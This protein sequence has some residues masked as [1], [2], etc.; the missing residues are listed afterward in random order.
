M[1]RFFIVI[2]PLI[3]QAKAGEVFQQGLIIM[4]DQAE[5]E[6]TGYHKKALTVDF[7]GALKSEIPILASKSIVYNALRRSNPK[8]LDFSEKII[9]VI[10]DFYLI[11]PLESEDELKDQLKFENLPKIS[12][13]EL[14]T[15]FATRLKMT[16]QRVNEFVETNKSLYSY[17][18]AP[19]FEKGENLIR[20]TIFGRKWRTNKKPHT[21]TKL[22]S[23]LENLMVSSTS[24]SWT[25]YLVGHG[26]F[27]LI[28]REE[29]IADL[30]LEE[31]QKFLDFCQNKIITE[32]LLYSSCYAGGTNLEKAFSSAKKGVEE[33]KIYKFPIVVMGVT[34]APSVAERSQDFEGLFSSLFEHQNDL[35]NY[36]KILRD[37]NFI[38]FLQNLPQVRLPGEKW[39]SI[40]DISSNKELMVL[41]KNSVPSFNDIL[42]I[43]NPPTHTI[44]VYLEDV[45]F[46][47]KLS[48]RSFTVPMRFILMR[49]DVTSYHFAKIETDHLTLQSVLAMFSSVARMTPFKY[50]LY[51]DLLSC[52]HNDKDTIRHFKN[53]IIELGPR[54]AK[55]YGVRFYATMNDDGTEVIEYSATTPRNVSSF[56][57]GAG[58]QDIRENRIAGLNY[59]AKFPLFNKDQK[60]S[61]VLEQT[62]RNIR[63]A[64]SISSSPSQGLKDLLPKASNMVKPPA[65]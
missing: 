41:S 17:L 22:I 14:Q 10:D 7:I 62:R 60:E 38:E 43:N 45:S 65:A 24:T 33:T 42:E 53:C 11:I 25:L 51:I 26:T 13:N 52:F 59:A 46:P 29:L 16:K 21:P 30:T 6:F 18:L 34:E 61:N 32:Q 5:Q 12:S 2:L 1:K 55:S 8:D 40:Q 27:S 36:Y 50:H 63:I 23:I 54:D 28:P 37:N 4:L 39:F 31:F 49:T 3:L 64:Q 57:T 35:P 9:K 15:S 48:D 56:L 44:F 20:S 19:V 47:L 58:L